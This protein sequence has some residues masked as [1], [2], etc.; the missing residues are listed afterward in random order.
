MVYKCD[1]LEVH[2]RQQRPRVLN[3]RALNLYDE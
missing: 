1:V 3:D 2:H